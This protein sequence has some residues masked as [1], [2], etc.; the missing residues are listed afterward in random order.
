MQDHLWY[1]LYTYSTEN[2]LKT[3][4][5]IE[6]MQLKRLYTKASSSWVKQAGLWQ[7]T[8]ILTEYACWSMSSKTFFL[9]RFSIM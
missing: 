1:A 2:V 5:F 6:F 9:G 4:N 7:L 8:H 3:F